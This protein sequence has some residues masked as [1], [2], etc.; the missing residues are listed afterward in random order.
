MGRQTAGTGGESGRPGGATV[1]TD[2]DV[3][4]LLFRHRRTLTAYLLHLTGGR[5]QLAEDL[6]NDVAAVMVQK[7]GQ[8]ADPAKFLPWAR[9]VT[10]NAAF[11]HFRRAPQE[12]LPLDESALDAME[13]VWNFAFSDEPDEA[14]P[15]ADGTGT[16]G[17]VGPVAGQGPSSAAG[18]GGGSPAKAGETAGSGRRGR[19]PGGDV[20][21][22][23]ECVSALTDQQ[24][25]VLWLRYG[26]SLP[27]AEI[28]RRRAVKA[29]TITRTLFRVKAALADCLGISMGE[30]DVGSV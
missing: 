8:L 16:A 4:R 15:H 7:A 13:S 26:E 2:S 30:S 12:P 23:A 9:T 19:R 29:E 3:V 24:R 1:A 18:T 11:A 17:A 5:R 21:R 25:D 14:G 27:T 20:G 22:L 10:R 6:L 28:A